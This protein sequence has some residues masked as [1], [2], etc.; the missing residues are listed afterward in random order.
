MA[1]YLS[2]ANHSNEQDVPERSSDDTEND[3][4]DQVPT[5]EN[6][7]N[8]GE[9]APAPS[10]AAVPRRSARTNKGVSPSDGIEGVRTGSR[11]PVLG[12]SARLANPLLNERNLYI[13]ISLYNEGTCC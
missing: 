12:T 7:N 5:E 11:E 8:T 1:P 6:R 9:D 10:N 13:S 2:E 4:H 3:V